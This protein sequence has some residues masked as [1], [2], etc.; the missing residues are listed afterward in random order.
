VHFC[1]IRIEMRAA[2]LSRLRFNRW[3]RSA[4]LGDGSDSG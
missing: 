1:A 4:V 2:Q 3:M